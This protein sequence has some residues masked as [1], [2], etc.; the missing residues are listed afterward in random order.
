MTGYGS[1]VKAAK[2]PPG[3]SVAVI[4]TGALGLNIVQTA[5]I[6][7]AHPIIAIDVNPL[8]LEAARRFGA[9]ET[10]LAERED[11]G[12]RR[13][14]EHVKAITG[15][16]GADYAFE[17]S[18][19]AALGAAPL[20]MIRNAGT[21]VQTSGIEE[22]LTIDMRLFEWD[23]TYINPRYGMC[24]P[25]VDFPL[26]MSLYRSGALLLDELITRT[27]T[28]DDLPQAFEDM[29]HGL[30]TKGVLLL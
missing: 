19:V 1:V 23:K 25:A 13:A 10:I 22:E 14:A 29:L 9:T 15:G 24:N 27:Y 30:N 12:L 6:V 26:L 2:L 7:G 21:A 20:A 8:K 16:R 4:G 11:A 3:A 17:A 18:A 28:L 5:R